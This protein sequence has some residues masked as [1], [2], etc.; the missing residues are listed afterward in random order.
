MPCGRLANPTVG[1]GSLQPKRASAVAADA[2]ASQEIADRIDPSIL[3]L[4]HGRNLLNRRRRC[5]G[6]RLGRVGR[7]AAARDLRGPVTPDGLKPLMSIAFLDHVARSEQR[8]GLGRQEGERGRLRRPFRRP[9][10]IGLT[11]RAGALGGSGAHLILRRIRPS[12]RFGTGRGESRLRSQRRHILR[13]QERRGREQ[14]DNHEGGGRE[15]RS[16]VF[17]TRRTYRQGS[18][19]A[20]PAL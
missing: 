4:R 19:S 12:I 8:D 17:H 16:V 9:V 2:Q 18:G 20:S 5:R 6:R 13:S 14:A 7:A 1:C 11:R 10:V 15:D 3:L